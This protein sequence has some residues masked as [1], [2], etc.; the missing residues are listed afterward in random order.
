[1]APSIISETA[2]NVLFHYNHFIY[3]N[4]LSHLYERDVGWIQIQIQIQILIH[5]LG[6][7]WTNHENRTIPVIWNQDVEHFWAGLFLSNLLQTAKPVYIIRL[8]YKLLRPVLVVNTSSY[9][10]Y[11]YIKVE[12]SAIEQHIL[13]TN[14]GKQLS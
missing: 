6:S 3:N 7:A 2:N 4:A 5:K 9:L 14:A 12:S 10:F 1:M 8:A 13:G 11:P